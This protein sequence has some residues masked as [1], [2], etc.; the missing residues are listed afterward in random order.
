[1]TC[2]YAIIV[3]AFMIL[4]QKKINDDLQV[5]KITQF[6]MIKIF[7][8]KKILLLHKKLLCLSRIII[9]SC[10]TRSKSWQ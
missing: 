8:L 9:S 5:T 2:G 6:V 7:R 1:M 10:V 4:L 3:V